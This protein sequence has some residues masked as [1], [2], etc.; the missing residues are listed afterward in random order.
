[1]NTP[2]IFAVLLLA[3]IAL[4]S[5]AQLDRSKRPEPGPPPKISF[6][7]YEEH[8]LPNGLRVFTVEDHKQPLVTFRLMIKS[9]MEYDGAGKSGIATF[10]ADLLTKG[11]E[12]RTSLAFAEE[13]DA[14]GITID[15]SAA[16][17]YVSVT[18]SGLKKHM[19]RMLELLADAIL[20]PVFPPE[21]IEKLRTQTLSNLAVE[22]KQPTEISTRLEITVGFNDHP[23]ANFPT[24]KSV[25]AIT[26][27]D[28][29][30]FHR[31]HFLPN[32][33]SL[34]VVGD[35]TP[36]EAAAAIAKHF[37]AWKKGM[38]P[39][40]DFPLPKPIR[41]TSVHLVD[42][43]STQTQTALCIV[44]TGMKRNNPDWRRFLVLNSILGG[45][46]SGR[47][48]NNL[49]EK[50]G[51][52]YGAYS[53]PDGRRQAGLWSISTE[54]RRVATDSAVRE[55]LSEIRRIN[56]DEPPAEELE[57]HKQYLVGTFLLS[58]ENPS[59]TAARVQDIDLYGLPKDY[60]RTFAS[61]ISGTTAADIRR[62][63]RMYIPPDHLAVTAVG[64]ASS[65]I[66]GLRTF[67]PVTMYDPDMERL[68][69]AGPET[70][71]IDAAELLTK[72]IEAQGGREKLLS[73]RDRTV[74]G[75][76]TLNF[77]G[78]EIEGSMVEIKKAPNKSYQRISMMLM[79]Q[80]MEQ[81]KWN[82]GSTVVTRNPMQ[83]TP[84]TLE[85]D[86]LLQELEQDQFNEFLRL[87]ELGYAA[88]VKAKKTVGDRKVYVL[89]VMKKYGKSV[90]LIDAQTWL[91]AGEETT[92]ETPEGPSTAT[93]FYDDYRPVDGV[94]VPH[95]IRVEGGPMKMTVRVTS[96]KQ[97][98]GVPDGTFRP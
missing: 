7:A 67:G 43:G 81:E 92:R 23:Y 59:V 55:I 70:P 21:E 64:D 9:G 68:E 42:L 62:L 47:F 11:T 40:A 35:V 85:G 48:Y 38:V 12:S 72:N 94:P 5:P 80:V 17:D 66:D 91:L 33:A 73:I 28:I 45:G 57:M 18:A 90:Y 6:P 26:R 58:L 20:H 78:Q 19:Q 84:V 15:V 41:G 14:C 8:V 98:T 97:N 31:Q 36:K 30:A 79:G 56:E 74:E 52:T 51:F 76:V 3:C 82:D 87:D 49:R 2:R 65:I 69:G 89:E 37:G 93:V 22:R 32:N 75:K 96:V 16:D 50:H 95:L 10:T 29:V 13:A 44:A 53:R 63:A 27:D 46:S 77:G 34:A 24:E 54:V 86:E 88:T 60:Y 71:D 83:Q 4:P 25:S 1:M 61:V 39:H